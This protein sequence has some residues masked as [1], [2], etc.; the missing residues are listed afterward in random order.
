M[1]N[2]QNAERLVNKFGINVAIEVCGEVIDEL[3]EDI[4]EPE[5]T[6]LDFWE[7]TLNLILKSK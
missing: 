2:K 4:Y 5:E 3:R 6:N 7:K 1:T